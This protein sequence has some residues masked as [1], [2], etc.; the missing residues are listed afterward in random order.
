[1]RT[2]LLPVLAILVTCLTSS[3][4]RRSDP[5]T[6]CEAGVGECCDSLLPGHPVQVC[7]H[8][9]TEWEVSSLVTPTVLNITAHSRERNNLPR[10]PPPE[11]RS[12]DNFDLRVLSL[13]AWGLWPQSEAKDERMAAIREF[14]EAG[15]RDL[16]FLQEVWMYSDYQ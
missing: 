10:Q 12:E 13:N 5:G 4:G 11:A 8:N 16:V 7:R 6:R 2:L 3:H 1:M 14:L 15:H 9:A